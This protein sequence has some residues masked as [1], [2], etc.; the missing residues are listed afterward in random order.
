MMIWLK[1]KITHNIESVPEGVSFVGQNGL[2]VE[3]DLK[4]YACPS[5]STRLQRNCL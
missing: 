5:Q 3:L 2:F 1:G 4:T